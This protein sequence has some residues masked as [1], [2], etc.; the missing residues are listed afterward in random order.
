MKIKRDYL[1][2]AGHARST[3]GPPYA[4]APRA[5]DLRWTTELFSPTGHI[6]AYAYI[7]SDW[8]APKHLHSSYSCILRVT[9]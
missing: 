9:K 7:R 6:W 2:I 4:Q 5:L 3:P 1:E 8:V